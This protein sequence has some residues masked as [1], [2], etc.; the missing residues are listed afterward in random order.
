[1]SKELLKNT[2]FLSEIK[3]ILKEHNQE[4]LD[5]ILFGSC[6][7]GKEKPKDIDL[8]V[9]YKS[10]KNIDTSYELK[11]N[12]K[13]QG[14]VVEITDKTYEEL[15]NGSFKAIEGILGEG[16]SFKSKKLLSESLGYLNFNLFKYNLKRL[17][18][19]E[20]MRF[21]YSLYGRTKNQQGIIKSLNSIKFSDSIILCPIDKSEEMSE[22]LKNWNISYTQFPILIPSRLKNIL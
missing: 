5:I 15:L 22:Y 18:K 14:F 19:S 17:N 1:M 13:S 21:Y 6:M 16:F 11:K 4:I 7:K 10:N 2:K 9:I 20:K 12:L 8:L 3:K